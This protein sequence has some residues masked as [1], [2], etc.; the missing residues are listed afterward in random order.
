[1]SNAEAQEIK[2]YIK[3][4]IRRMRMEFGSAMAMEGMDPDLIIRCQQRVAE[5][6]VEWLESK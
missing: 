5:G 6:M 3:D 4:L 1:M 2:T